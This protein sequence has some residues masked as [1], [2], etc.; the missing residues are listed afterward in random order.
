VQPWCSTEIQLVSLVSPAT[1]REAKAKAPVEDCERK[2]IEFAVF[3]FVQS[4]SE[5]TRVLIVCSRA[6]SPPTIMT[7]TAYDACTQR[8]Q[9]HSIPSLPTGSNFDQF[10]NAHARALFYLSCLRR[11]RAL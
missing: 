2:L 4:M 5:G 7:P 3:F 10:F 9:I 6:I 8:N 1:S 11:V